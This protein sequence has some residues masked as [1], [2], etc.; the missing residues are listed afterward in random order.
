M[1][2]INKSEEAYKTIGEITKELN[3]VD[4]KTGSLELLNAKDCAVDSIENL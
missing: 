1:K 3:L 4:K 2:L